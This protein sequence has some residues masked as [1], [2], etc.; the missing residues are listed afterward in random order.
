MKKNIFNTNVN[1]KGDIITQTVFNIHTDCIPHKTIAFDN[2]YSSR[3]S[4]KT[5][6]L[7]HQT[8]AAFKSFRKN[9]LPYLN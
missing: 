5:E 2:K 3:F 9:K 1:E 7:I 8:N 4:N 6:M